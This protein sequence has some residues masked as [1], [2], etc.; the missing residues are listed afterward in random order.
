MV[1]CAAGMVTDVGKLITAAHEWHWDVEV[2]ATPQGLG[3]LD[4][5]AVEAQTGHPTRSAWRSPGEPRPTRPAVAI[6]VAPASFNTVNKWAA[7]ISDSL[8]LGVLREAPAMGIPVAVLP[9]L[10]SAQ[11]AHPAYRQSLARLREMGALI[12]SHEPHRPKASGGADHYRLEEAL[13]LL[14]PALSARA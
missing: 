9:Y 4:V 10:S 13:E 2:I 5:E 7:G 11:D 1:V 12:G 14:A 6:A 3:F 8:A